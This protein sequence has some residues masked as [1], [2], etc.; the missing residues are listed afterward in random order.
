MTM[1]LTTAG[2]VAL[3]RALAGDG[4][5]VFTHVKIGSGAAQDPTTVSELME[6]QKSFDITGLTVADGRATLSVTLDNATVSAGFHL[7]EVGIYIQDLDDSTAEILYAYGS[8]TEDTAD[9]VAASG[10]NILEMVMTYDCFVSAAENVSA[11]I[12]ESLQYARQV[13]FQAHLDDRENPHAVTKAQV[14]L[15]NVENYAPSDMPVSFTMPSSP[16]APTSGERLGTMM[17]KITR[18]VTNW[19]TGILGISNG[20]TG[21]SSWTKDGV[22]YASATNALGQI[23]RPTGSNMFL[24]QGSSSG[25]P[26]WS[27]VSASEHISKKGTGS[28]SASSLASVTFSKL[29]NLVYIM[30]PASSGGVTGWGVLMPASGYGYSMVNGVWTGLVVSTSGTTVKWYGVSGGAA[31]H[32]N[33]A[34]WTYHFVG[35]Y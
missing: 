2:S 5:I 7:T 17:G 25:A 11:I 14:G 22:V 31:N 15:G 4:D 20:G 24:T 13:D 23:A 34:G 30:I 18:A 12:N 3:T 8:D 19:L 33:T 28:T 10:D 6:I 29:P 32:L 1:T 21:R 35:I 26:Q 27:L 16:S 9:Y